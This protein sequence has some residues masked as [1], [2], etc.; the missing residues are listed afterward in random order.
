M[1]FLSSAGLVGSAISGGLLDF[2][3]FQEQKN[4]NEW[5]QATQ[6]KQWEREDTAY[7]RTA[8]DMLN[9]GLNPLTMQ[10]TDGAGELISP[11]TPQMST[12][13]STNLMNSFV[14]QM[15]SIA[16]G[17][18]ERDLLQS[19]IDSQRLQNIKYARDNGLIYNPRFSNPNH[20]TGK[21][22]YTN[23]EYD[24]NGNRI[25]TGPDKKISVGTESYDYNINDPYQIQLLENDNKVKKLLWDNMNIDNDEKKGNYQ[26]DT[27][28]ERNLTTLQKWLDSER[29]M[30]L[31]EQLRDTGI[32]LGKGLFG[33]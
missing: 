8:Q 29:L 4:M 9:A 31:F 14:N 13:N 24:E 23:F 19:Q 28:I 16:T 5:Q 15:E 25:N 7:Q 22:N 17:K 30:S 18:Q 21:Y 2:A 27:K 10:G 11:D 1:G 33:L 12:E 20:R 26:N 6:K 32:G 3:N